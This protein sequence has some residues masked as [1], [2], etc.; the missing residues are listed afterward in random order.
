MAYRNTNAMPKHDDGSVLHL[1][2]KAGQVANRVVS[3]GSFGRAKMLARLLDEG[4]Y[5]TVE[6]ARGFAT[7]TGKV[8]GVPVSI[9]ATGMV[10]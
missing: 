10:R 3:V 1:G 2:V 7:F 6:S 5:E 9:V 4:Q 8:K